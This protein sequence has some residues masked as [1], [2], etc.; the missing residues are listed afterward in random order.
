LFDN[1]ADDQINRAFRE[2][3]HLL[4]PE[5]IRN[6]RTALRLSRE[7]LAARLG[8]EEEVLKGWEE[9]QRIQSRLADNLLRLYFA[10]PPVRLALDGVEAHSDL[11][12]AVVD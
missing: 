9:G 7:D 2:Q 1:W 12:A 3:L 10:L 6:N 11:G 8:I 4:S 5:Q